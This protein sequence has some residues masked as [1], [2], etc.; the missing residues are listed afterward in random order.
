MSLVHDARLSAL[1]L[2]TEID[3]FNTD[4]ADKLDRQDLT[5]WAGCFIE[6]GFYTVISR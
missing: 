3:D 4:Y 1:L 5:A 6:D 2:R